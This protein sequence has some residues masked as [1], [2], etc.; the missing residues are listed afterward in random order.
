MFNQAQLSGANLR[1][2]Y[3][4]R[5]SFNDTALD[6]VNLAWGD[7]RTTEAAFASPTAKARG[8]V[9]AVDDRGGGTR[10]VVDSPYQFSEAESGVARGAGF[11]GEHN[12]EVL[13][14]WLGASPDEIAELE[15]AG[16]L[17]AEGTA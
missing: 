8:T 4:A 10:P 13:A 5:A 1:Y 17:L 11:L 12:R 15:E 7:V 2:A 9:A 3:L 16:V 6:G 14:E